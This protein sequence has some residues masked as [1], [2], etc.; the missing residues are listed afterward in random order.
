MSD[1]MTEATLAASPI[2]AMVSEH[3]IGLHLMG[4]RLTRLLTIAAMGKR[5]ATTWL[6]IMD[7][8]RRSTIAAKE[9]RLVSTPRAMREVAEALRI[10]AMQLLLATL[11][12]KGTL[13]CLRE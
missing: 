12:Q 2:V 1:M 6:D 7:T 8:F 5:L 10:H 13:I 4:V 3:A 11:A 9:K